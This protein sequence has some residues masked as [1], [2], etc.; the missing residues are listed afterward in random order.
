[1]LCPAIETLR[2]PSQDVF[3]VAVGDIFSFFLHNVTICVNRLHDSVSL[4]KVLIAKN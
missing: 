4:G 3:L 1:M 2:V